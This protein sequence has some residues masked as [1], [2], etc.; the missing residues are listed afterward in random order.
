MPAWNSRQMPYPLLAPWSDDYDEGSRFAATVP[1]AVLTSNGSVNLHIQYEL[2]SPTLA[3]LIDRGKAQFVALVACA[4][5]FTRESHPTGYPEQHLVLNASDYAD[6]LLLTPHVCAAADIAGFKSLEHSAEYASVRPQG[7]QISPATILAIGDTT[8]VALE[9]SGNPYSIIDLV[10]D[11]STSVGRFDL[12][13]GEDRIKI[14]L[15]PTD[16]D[17][18]DVYRSRGEHSAE[19]VSLVASV[20]LHAVTEAI[21]TL[22]EKPTKQWHKTIRWALAKHGIQNSD[23]ELKREAWRHAQTI[24]GNP[25]GNLLTV[26]AKRDDED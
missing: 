20:Y 25:L 17:A 7:F 26:F 12:A 6:T 19:L 3:D 10:A 21:R 22:P 24:T 18:I 11:Q 14:H 15:S 4:H 16:R 1:S 5:T 9:S 8:A 23:E 2:F 13:L